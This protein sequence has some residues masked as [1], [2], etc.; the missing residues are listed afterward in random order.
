MCFRNFVKLLNERG[1]FVYHESMAR[2]CL[3]KIM[4][5]SFIDSIFVIALIRTNFVINIVGL[6]DGD[7]GKCGEGQKKRKTLIRIKRE[8]RFLGY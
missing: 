4:T 3:V 6:M 8:K 5:N 7:S 1:R 2:N